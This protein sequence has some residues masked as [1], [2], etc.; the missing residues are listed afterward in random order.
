MKYYIGL[1]L[2]PVSTVESGLA[3]IED[4]GK[5]I[6][7]D[8][9]FKV[10]DIT[11]FFDN[12]SS[13]KQSKI[14]VSLPW[15]NTMLEGKWRILSKPYQQVAT[16]VHMPNRENWTQRYTKRGCEYFCELKERGI[17]IVRTELYLARQNLKL[18][19]YFKERTPADCKFL[20]NTLKLEYGF[21]EIPTNM[22]PAAQLEA[23][24]CAL[25]ARK[26]DIEKDKTKELFDFNGIM[27]VI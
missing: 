23:I 26:Y 4:T 6:L 14:C 10:K 21:E 5:I 17:D 2:A 9:L 16:N 7:I 8:K 11:L 20:Q 19:S 25:I 3:V 12:Y 22:M 1:A 15:D 24:V 13:L 18:S 27:T